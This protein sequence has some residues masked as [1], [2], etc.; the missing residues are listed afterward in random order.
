M[1]ISLIHPSRGRGKKAFETYCYWMDRAAN[2]NSIEH[3]LSVDSSDPGLNDYNICFDHYVSFDNDCVVSATNN[4]AAVSTGDILVYLSDD[5]K[6]PDNWDEKII[7]RFHVME[8]VPIDTPLLIKVDDCLQP[9]NKDVLT[10]PIMNRALYDR[11]G[12]FWNPLYK[13]MFVDQDLY[14]VCRKNKWLMSCEDLKFP[15]EHYSVGKAQRD[16]TNIRSDAHWN[17]GQE[18][19]KRRQQE[20]FK[21]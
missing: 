7:E 5:F 1:K 11:L 4:A 19:Y 17:S 20:G 8:S 10:I 2:S 3:I 6:C 12:Y 21:I 15:H 13:S 16:E 18:I 14:W 9:F